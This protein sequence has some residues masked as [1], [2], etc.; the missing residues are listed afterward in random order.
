MLKYNQYIKHAHLICDTKAEAIVV[1]YVTAHK[2]QIVTC[3]LQS[4]QTQNC[5]VCSLS[6]EG[7]T[8][9]G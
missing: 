7:E 5:L 1:S 3:S 8:G 9:P 2:P 4:L 6:A